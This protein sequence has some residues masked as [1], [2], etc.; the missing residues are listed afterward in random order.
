MK[1]ETTCLQFVDN[2]WVTSHYLLTNRWGHTSW[3]T[4]SG[5]IL[6]IGGYHEEQTTELV[7]SDGTTELGTLQ[8]K[9]LST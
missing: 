8:L 1:T 4:Q 2:K 7:K 5:D 6:L 3:E 9:Y